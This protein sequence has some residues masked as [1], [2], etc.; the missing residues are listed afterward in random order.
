MPHFHM[1]L[2]IGSTTAK[3]VLLDDMDRLVLSRYSG[4]FPMSDRQSVI[5]LTKLSI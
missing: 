3:A 1:G 4:I 5:F 2:D